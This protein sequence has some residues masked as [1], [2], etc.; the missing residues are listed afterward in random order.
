MSP[1]ETLAHSAPQFEPTETPLA[2]EPQPLAEDVQWSRLSGVLSAGIDVADT[3]CRLQ[4]EAADQLDAA[5]YSL[6]RMLEEL[7]GVMPTASLAEA[8]TSPQPAATFDLVE[9]EVLAA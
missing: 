1:D 8:V 4:R 3:A 5:Q 7:V 6:K 2:A 9:V